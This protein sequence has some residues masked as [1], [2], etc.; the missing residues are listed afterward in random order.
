MGRL[1][2]YNCTAAEED[3]RLGR[4]GGHAS[5]TI[6]GVVNHIRAVDVLEGLPYADVGRLASIGHSLGGH[7]SI[8]AG[9]FD[10]RI[11][12][13]VASCG[14]TP[15]EWGVTSMQPLRPGL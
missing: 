1:S 4:P 11:K 14:W 13:V 8:F 7:N 3:A 5:C 2:G 6:K 12:V 9:V 15:C 10:P